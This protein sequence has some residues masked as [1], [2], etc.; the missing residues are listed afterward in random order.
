MTDFADRTIVVTG[1]TR[2]IGRAICESFLSQGGDVFAIGRRAPDTPIVQKDR[3]ACFISADIRDDAALQDAVSAC[4][5]QTGRFDVLVNNAGGSPEVAALDCSANMADKI[6]ALNLTSAFN[7]SRHAAHHMLAQADGGA[8]INIASVSGTRPSP[9]TAVYGAA[10]AGLIS[11]TQSLA[12]EWAPQIRLN[13]IVAGMVETPA[14]IDHYGGDA[15]IDRINAS[16]PM[17]RMAQPDDIAKA[18]LFLAGP[19]SSYVTGAT[20]EV[21]GGGE[22]PPFLSLADRTK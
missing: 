12:Q 13:A 10:K 5:S 14:A 1:G 4:F 19:Q 16:L 17:Q 20:L 8:I 15:G 9:G 11:L 2:G 21:H 6:I 22:I 18:C 3:T 7:A